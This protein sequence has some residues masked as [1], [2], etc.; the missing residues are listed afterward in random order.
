MIYLD[1]ERK[2]NKDIIVGFIKR[3]L[4]NLVEYNI[5]MVKY[6]D[7]GRNSMCIVIFFLLLFKIFILLVLYVNVEVVIEFIV[8]FF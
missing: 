2:F 1:E 6:F 3:E 5:Y 4:L 7:V 8:L